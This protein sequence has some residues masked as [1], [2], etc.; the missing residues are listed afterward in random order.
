VWALES[1]GR[2]FED[3][4]KWKV[5]DGREI[6][7]WEDSWL[8]CGALKRVFPRLF[9]LSSAKAAKVAELGVWTDGVWV[10]HLG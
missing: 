1:W 2:S 7:F 6:S 9:S 3:V 5:G 4:F 8:N 10:W